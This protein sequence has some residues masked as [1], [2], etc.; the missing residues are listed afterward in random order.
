[1]IRQLNGLNYCFNDNEHG[2]TRYR[3]AIRHIILKISEVWGSTL[4][5]PV[6]KNNNK[7]DGTN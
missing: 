4:I 6:N 7:K 5:T 2:Q 3:G 1:M